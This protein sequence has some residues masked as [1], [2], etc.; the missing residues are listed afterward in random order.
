MKKRLLISLLSCAFLLTGCGLFGGG[1]K[2][3]DPVGPVDPG[4][5]VPTLTIVS[6]DKLQYQSAGAGY[7]TL[8]LA[9]NETY[10]LNANLGDY[11]G[12][13]YKI[14]YVWDYS[15]SYTDCAVI[16]N[17]VIS[18]KSTTVSGDRAR[19]SVQ[20]Q[21]QGSSKAIEKKNIYITFTDVAI[22][23][24]ST[25]SEVTV[26][27]EYS[28]FY[29][30]VPIANVF[31]PLPRVELVND[32]REINIE[33]VAEDPTKIDFQISELGNQFKIYEHLSS[34]FVEFDIRITDTDG[35]LITSRNCAVK[36]RIDVDDEDSYY[37]TYGEDETRIKNGETIYL[38]KGTTTD[39][40]LYY[41]GARVGAT[42]SFTSST[43]STYARLYF[44]DS[45]KYYKINAKEVGSTD[46]EI[47]RK[48]VYSDGSEKIYKINFTIS[49][50]FNKELTDIYVP[51]GKD[52]FSINGNNVYVNGKIYAVYALKDNEGNVVDHRLEC[53]NGDDN[54]H[55]SVSGNVITLSYMTVQTQITVE[56]TNKY[57]KT[58]LTK[59]YE[60][61]TSYTNT[62]SSGELRVLAL[63]I[64][65]NDSNEFIN[66]EKVDTNNKTQQEQI[67]EDLNTCLFGSNNNFKWRGLR[68]YYLE[69][70]YGNLNITGKV[71]PW[72]NSGTSYKDYPHQ[73]KNIT[74]L[75]ESAVKY[76][77]DNNPSDSRDNYDADGDGKIDAV[78]AFYG[79]NYHGSGYTASNV[80]SMT[81]VR[82]NPT[83]L[84]DNYIDS[85]AWISALEIY[86]LGGIFN[87]NS[88]LNAEDLSKFSLYPWTESIIHEFGHI[89]GLRDVY[90]TSSLY[91]FPDGL[92][93]M[94]SHDCGGHDPLANMGLGFASPYVFDSS[95]TSLDN[96]SIITIKDFQSSG[97]LIILTP[98]WNASKEVF[99]EYIVLELYSPTGLN[100]YHLGQNNSSIGSKVP[101]VRVWHINAELVS[102][103]HKYSNAMS[104]TNFDLVH[105][106]RNDKNETFHTNTMFSESFLFKQ[107]DSF[108]M[109][110][111]KSQFYNADG[112]LDNGLTLGWSF[113]IQSIV[114]DKYGS[115]TATIK[116]TK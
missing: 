50:Y 90:D 112:K 104:E 65:F 32:T 81:W 78:M 70:S 21:K 93:T 66:N 88:Q 27:E 69:E 92:S 60:N 31:Y 107:G 51:S 10:T 63:P 76:Y 45:S 16:E 40:Y 87:T 34:P 8:T 26:K 49:V 47:T 113:E 84:T 54:L 77:F 100:E 114:T 3:V 38:M 29:I 102:G 5:T 83:G 73:G 35:N 80:H 17:N 111:F 19:L 108:D 106:I 41:N 82:N 56:G 98:Q 42:K 97:D 44:G 52:A 61:F 99:D 37:L 103:K 6:D 25:S 7:Y 67:I 13:Q 15:D 28:S 74:Q 115:A 101:G 85:Y 18:P 14:V 9:I 71:A 43:G 89:L 91:N 20:L 12:T 33:Y 53:I 46:I 59:N 36:E 86:G 94:Q 2:P 95:D 110:S 64:F 58:K 75:V 1:D 39:A 22:R 55:I 48:M 62:R 11:T 23:L 109:N 72:Y 79:S 24:I 4:E 57:T 96:E 68:T 30:T 116:L 105:L